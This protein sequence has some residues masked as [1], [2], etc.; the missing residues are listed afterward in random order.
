LRNTKVYAQTP[1]CAG[2]LV[3]F[4]T[5]RTAGEIITEAIKENRVP[6]YLLYG[7]AITFVI[8][9][10]VLIGFAVAHGSGLN[11]AAGVALNGL[12]W[13]AYGQTKKLRQENLMLRMLEIPLSKAQT[14]QEAAKMLTE[15]F[16]QHFK[17]NPAP[18]RRIGK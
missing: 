13:P 18:Q 10:E 6:E 11:A 14:A 3:S 15:A 1:E 5:M 7:L 16:A 12:A 9:G 4:L 8:T 17:P 2:I